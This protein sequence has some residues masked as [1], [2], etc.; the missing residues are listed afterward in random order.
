MTKERANELLTLNAYINGGCLASGAVRPSIN[1]E[2]IE[3]RAEV[4][5]IWKTLPGNATMHGVLCRIASGEITSPSPTH[6]EYEAAI[7]GLEAVADDAERNIRRLE[8]K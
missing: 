3:E 2:T 4:V 6:T 8:A 1:P 5:R 7:A